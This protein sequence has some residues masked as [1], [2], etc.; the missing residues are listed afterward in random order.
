[1]A[2]VPPRAPAEKSS[3]AFSYRTERGVLDENSKL[4]AILKKLDSVDR[5]EKELHE[6]RKDM[7]DLRKSNKN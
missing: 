1:M 3:R 5:L 7:E 6:L 2:P 4:D